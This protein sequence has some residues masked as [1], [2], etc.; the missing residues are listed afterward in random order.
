VGGR[1]AWV[2]GERLKLAKAYL[3]MGGGIFVIVLKK[4]GG[5]AEA[6]YVSYFQ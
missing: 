4:N 1:A 3:S 6:L 5:K 2:L